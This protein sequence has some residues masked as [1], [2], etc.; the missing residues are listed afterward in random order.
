MKDITY[1]GKKSLRFVQNS[2]EALTMCKNFPRLNL[3]AKCLL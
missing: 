1:I 2:L 3:P